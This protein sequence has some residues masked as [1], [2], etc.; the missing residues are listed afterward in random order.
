MKRLR[1]GL[2]FVVL[3][4]CL[5]RCQSPADV[6]EGTPVWELPRYEPVEPV[7]GS[8]RSVGS[9]TMNSLL[10]LWAQAVM[11]H[12]PDVK[13]EVEGKGSATAPLALIT[14]KCTFGVMSRPMKEQEAAVFKTTFGYGATCVPVAI[15]MLA[16]YVHRD[17]P[18]PGVTLP[19]L[20][21]LFSKTRKLGHNEP[22][23]RWGQLGL[24]GV[25]TRRP[26]RLYGRNPASG[27]YAYLLEHGLGK[28][29]Y[30]DSVREQRGS[31]AVVQRV[32][33]DPRAIGYSGIGYKTD[34]VR[35]LALATNTD[36]PFV[37]ATVENGVSGTYPLAR[38]LYVYVNLP[39]DTQPPPLVAEFVRLALSRDGQEIVGKVGFVPLPPP[40]V[41][42]SLSAVRLVICG[43]E[44]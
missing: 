42:R 32:A 34:G 3:I 36:S 21:A 22:I 13:V 17:N 14:G 8:I 7:S 27:T 40:Q 16:I 25:W 19:Q 15:D 18:L 37:E 41:L 24:D 5:G 31:A 44:R 6:E 2:L 23:D 1:K 26:V 9:D 43:G 38:F 11:E 30:R 12:H 35:A 29:A 4:P 10:T 20:D 33:D 28:G 39:P